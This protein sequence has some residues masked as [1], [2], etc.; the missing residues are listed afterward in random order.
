MNRFLAMTGAALAVA[1]HTAGAQTATAPQQAVPQTDAP[2]PQAAQAQQ[3]A[4]PLLAS[5]SG[6]QVAILENG[7]GGV[8]SVQSQSG[9][10]A[11]L[12]FITP[13]AAEAERQKADDDAMMVSIIDLPSVLGNWNGAVIFSS[14]P[15]EVEN[16]KTLA[17]DTEDFLAPVFFV[18]NG[19]V[20]AA[21]QT[22]QGVVTPILTSYSD[23]EGMANKLKASGN[24]DG[25][26]EIVP[27]EMATLLQAIGE[28]EADTG[29]RFFTHPQ[30]IAL[31]NQMR[32]QQQEQQQG[33]AE[34]G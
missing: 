30:T 9:Q 28:Q 16:A 26:V 10:P 5:L 12:A 11:I 7:E 15:E 23:A 25:T 33:E 22:R 20:E 24:A 4:D 2:Q 27:I 32:E 13:Q 8:A 3:A 29:Y 6:L 1:L 14:S 17:P 34:G 19:D 31:I 21:I 18:M